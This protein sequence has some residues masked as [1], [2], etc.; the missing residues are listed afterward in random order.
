MLDLGFM[1]FVFQ[2]KA[3]PNSTLFALSGSSLRFIAVNSSS[4]MVPSASHCE[5]G[6]GLC[7]MESAVRVCKDVQGGRQCHAGTGSKAPGTAIRSQK[8]FNRPDRR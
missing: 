3:F 4:I 1:S 7:W 8:S 2:G 6:D 5:A